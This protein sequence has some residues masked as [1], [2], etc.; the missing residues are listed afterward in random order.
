VELS[1]HKVPWALR[2]VGGAPVPEGKLGGHQAYGKE[3]MQ[4]FALLIPQLSI[5]TVQNSELQNMNTRSRKI[6][7][8]G[9]VNF[10]KVKK[11]SKYRT[12]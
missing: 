2:P 1:G 7:F 12:P 5:Y 11:C 6:D 8:Y 9:N 10:N 4:L 3:K